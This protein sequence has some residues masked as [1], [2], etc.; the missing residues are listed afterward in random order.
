MSASTFANFSWS[1]LFPKT[2]H[3]EA[4]HKLLERSSHSVSLVKDKI[5]IFGGEREPR[6]PIDDNLMMYDL[7]LNKWSVAEVKS[8]ERPMARIGNASCVVN[9]KLY[10][11]GG[12]TGIEMGE[13]S[14]NDLYEYDT[15]TNIWNQLKPNLISNENPPPRSYHTMTSLKNKLYVFG[16]CS[17]DHGRLNDLFEFDLTQNKWK[18]LKSDDRIAPRGGSSLCSF[19]SSNEAAEPSCLYLVGGFKG[20]ELDDVFKYDLAQDVWTQESSMPRKLSVFAGSSVNNDKL[21]IDGKKVRL[22]VH[23]GE[24]DPS[25][26]GHNGAGEFSS[27]IYAFN[28]DKWHILS[29]NHGEKPSNRGWHAGCYGFDNKFYIFGGNL[30][31]NNRTNELWSLNFE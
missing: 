14:L 2:M 6:I 4:I 9:H 26:K 24:I 10:V 30:E 3:L 28:G 19:E 1:L 11:F 20:E 12:R 5:Y 27:D 13:G 18:Q 29:N 22:L 23:G 16:G 17:A 7:K 31:D 21:I 8:V 25:T 15:E